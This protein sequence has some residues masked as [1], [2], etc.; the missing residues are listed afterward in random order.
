MSQTKI[1]ISNLSDSVISALSVPKISSIDYP[2]D[3][4]AANPSGNQLITLNG[5]GFNTGAQVYIDG[6]IVSVVTVLSSVQLT[7]LSPAK[8]AGSYELRVV[9][10]DGGLAASVNNIQYSGVPNWITSSGSLANVYEGV[11]VTSILSAS[12]D[13]AVSYSLTSGSLPNGVS[14]SGNLIS[15]TTGS[16]VGNTTYN[17]VIDAIDEELQNTSRN[18]SIGVLADAVTWSNPANNST[19]T[20]NVDTQITQVLSATALTGSNITYSANTLP[21]GLS[22]VADTITGNATVV[23]NTTSLLTATSTQSGKTATRTINFEI[24]SGA[25]PIGQVEYTT[26]GTYSCTVPAGITSVAAVCVGAGAIS[27]CRT[28]SGGGGLR[29]INNL[30]VTPGET[31]SVVVG[32][33][34]LAYN[35]GDSSISRSSNILV[36]G[37]GGGTPGPATPGTGSTIGAGT[38]GGTIG[39]GD[40]GAGFGVGDS[41]GGAGGGGAGGYS[42]NGG[43]GGRGGG[44]GTTGGNGSGGGGGGGGGGSTA[45]MFTSNGGRGGGV[46]IYGE[47]T[48]GAGGA[49]GSAGQPGVAGSGGSG[50][51]YGGGGSGKASDPYGTNGAAGS[52][53]VRIIW[54]QNRSF[55]ATNTQ[56]M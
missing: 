47:G 48:S 2:D 20:A 12:S 23:A 32:A 49:G 43:L 52:G 37:G 29:Y 42:G 38:Y 16:V 17:F 6:T 27:A 33:P 28:G 14:L 4:T 3:D 22:I 54:G 55:P 8:S 56:N 46:G 30:P 11:S 44:T 41:I 26:A 15:G 34:G 21:S 53:A 39:G 24:Q 36:F 19:I 13:S 31:L 5:A 9:N 51:L 40:G 18:F 10:T 1:D 35:P 50:V 7:F 25:S 45:N